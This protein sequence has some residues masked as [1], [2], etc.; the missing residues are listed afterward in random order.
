[1]GDMERTRLRAEFEQLQREYR[2]MEATRRVREGGERVQR[3]R[4]APLPLAK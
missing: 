4:E 1:M 2:N 3:T